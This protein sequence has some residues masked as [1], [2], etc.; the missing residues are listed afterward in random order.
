MSEMAMLAR[1]AFRRMRRRGFGAEGQ[2]GA[3][4]DMVHALA[5]RVRY[6]P[7]GVD[8]VFRGR[9]PANSGVTMRCQSLGAGKA[10]AR[11]G[12]AP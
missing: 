9:K 8:K 5:R 1:T 2:I 12:W 10:K 6:A 11:S 7:D 4:G 3:G